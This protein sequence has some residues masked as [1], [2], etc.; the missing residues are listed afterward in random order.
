MTT[1]YIALFISL[2]LAAYGQ[3]IIKWR[4]NNKAKHLTSYPKNK[5]FFYLSFAS[6]FFIISAIAVAFIRFPLWI[7]ILSKFD[8]SY[9]YSFMSL[10]FVIILLTSKLFFGESI[11]IGKITGVLLVC[12]GISIMS[13]SL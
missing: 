5:I 13:I 2:L 1:G 11:N 7:F 6:D 4:V 8:L 9:A 12:A 3:N 10:N